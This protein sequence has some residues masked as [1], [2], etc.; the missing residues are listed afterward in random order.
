M[1]KEDNEIEILS[2]EEYPVAYPCECNHHTVHDYRPT[3]HVYRSENDLCDVSRT[4]QDSR[5]VGY[6][7]RCEPLEDYESEEDKEEAHR[8][9]RISRA[10]MLVALGLL[11]M[12]VILVGATLG[13]SSKMDEMVRSNIG[14]DTS[15]Q[16]VI[17]IDKELNRSSNSTT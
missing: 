17:V 8:K 12:S 3:Y 10:I 15:K 16:A 9:K 5:M 13:M 1:D 7:T 6:S 4:S 11:L 14:A 2:T